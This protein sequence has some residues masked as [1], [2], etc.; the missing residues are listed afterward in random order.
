MPRFTSAVSDVSVSVS[1][2]TAELLGFGVG[3]R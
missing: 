3:G 2:E 1:D